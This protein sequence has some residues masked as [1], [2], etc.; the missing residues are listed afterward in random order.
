MAHFAELD[1]LNVVLRVLVVS[2]AD[3]T[4][5]NG[6]EQE[7]LGVSFLQGLFG[8]QTRWAQT[9]YN[10]NFRR[11]YAGPGDVYDAGRDA[12][13]PPKPSEDWLFSEVSWSWQAPPPLPE[14]D[15]PWTWDEATGQ[16]IAA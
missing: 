10:A 6:Q 13:V 3:I 12:F 5:G 8:A 7:Q 16:W 2:N 1:P 14:G 11:K 4:D 9:S 15:G